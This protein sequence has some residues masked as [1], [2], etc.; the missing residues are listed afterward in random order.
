[1]CGRRDERSELHL[2]HYALHGGMRQKSD[3][4]ALKAMRFPN[5]WG[6]SSHDPAAIN[7]WPRGN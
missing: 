4:T 3:E 5:F 6:D 2:P 1:M 7:H